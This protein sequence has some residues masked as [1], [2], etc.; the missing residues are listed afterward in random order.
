MSLLP[1]ACP[2]PLLQALITESSAQLPLETSGRGFSTG[3]QARHWPLSDPPLPAASAPRSGWCGHWLSQPPT[4]Y[5]LAMSAPAP[6]FPSG[7][8]HSTIPFPTTCASGHPLAVPGKP[9]LTIKTSFSLPRPP[10][11]LQHQP[12]P[13]A[14]MEI[15]GPSVPPRP[16]PSSHFLLLLP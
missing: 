11:L 7:T 3:G 15:W 13:M 16:P 8:F 6:S 9:H 1:E 2:H 5:T 14:L 10:N 4:L 12:H